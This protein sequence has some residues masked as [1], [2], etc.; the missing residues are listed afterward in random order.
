[1]MFYHFDRTRDA[2]QSQRKFILVGTGRHSRGC[3]RL[4]RFRKPSGIAAWVSLSS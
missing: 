1:M 2:G 4:S 3:L